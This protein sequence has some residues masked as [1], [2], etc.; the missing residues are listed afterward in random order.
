M[1]DLTDRT[2]QADAAAEQA[3]REEALE[4]ELAR[5]AHHA[6][7]A[8]SAGEIRHRH[9]ANNLH[10]ATVAPGPRLPNTFALAPGASTS[11]AP[12]VSHA[13]PA[14]YAPNPARPPSA[15]FPV[16]KHPFDRYPIDRYPASTSFGFDDN[17][18]GPV[19]ARKRIQ[20]CR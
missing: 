17:V 18:Y 8:N 6:R 16:E 19:P 4:R 9:S 5:A 10:R 15:A 20:T 14:K 13:R 7:I 12:R 11:Y 3:A 1:Q 2:A